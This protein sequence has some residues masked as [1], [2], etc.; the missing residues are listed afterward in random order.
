MFIE[1]FSGNFPL[2]AEK[3]NV[4]KYKVRTNVVLNER[5]A[6]ERATVKESD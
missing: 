5:K 4:G 1:R 6:K 3:G 2:S